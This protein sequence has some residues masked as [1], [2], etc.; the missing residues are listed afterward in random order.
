MMAPLFVSSVPV[1]EDLEGGSWVTLLAQGG[2]QNLS[3]TFN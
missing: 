3:T 1:E 2:G